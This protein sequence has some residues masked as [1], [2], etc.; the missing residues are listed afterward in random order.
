MHG[1]LV[2][3]NKII[4]FVHRIKLKKIEKKKYIKFISY[5]N[6]KYKNE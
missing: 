6:I 3:K 2:K 5:N 4:L 1:H